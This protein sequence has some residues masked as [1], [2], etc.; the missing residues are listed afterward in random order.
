MASIRRPGG[1]VRSDRALDQFLHDDESSL[2]PS[3]EADG[4][5]SARGIVVRRL[6][7]VASRR[8]D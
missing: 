2:V 6:S 3:F 7:G 4:G 5:P 1:F 8:P